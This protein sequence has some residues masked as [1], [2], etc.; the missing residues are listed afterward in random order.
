MKAG[1]PPSRDRAKPAPTTQHSAARAKNPRPCCSSGLAADALR[2]EPPCPNTLA[3]TGCI[4]ARVKLSWRT[5]RTPDPKL[6]R[7]Q[8]LQQPGQKPAPGP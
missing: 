6:R 1:A 8:S 4:Q 5:I 2:A 7:T 3:E